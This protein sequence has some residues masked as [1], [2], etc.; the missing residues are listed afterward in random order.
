MTTSTAKRSAIIRCLHVLCPSFETF[1]YETRDERQ[2]RLDANAAD[3]WAC[4]RHPQ[5]RRAA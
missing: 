2:A 3:P 1:V 4:G 5:E